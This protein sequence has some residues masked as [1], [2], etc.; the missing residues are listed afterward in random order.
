MEILITIVSFLLLIALI[1]SPILILIGLK[2]RKIE[3]YKFITYLTL[4]VFITSI[5]T[6]AFGWWSDTSREILL[7]YYGYEFDS[8][9]ETERFANV[10]SENLDRVKSLE[11]SMMG[12]GWPL[13]TIITFAL[14]S[15]YL[16]FI[17]VV[18]YLIQKNQKTLP[19]QTYDNHAK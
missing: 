12:I 7:S 11:I 4:G 6:L 17:Y 15:P 19:T 5:I 18:T 8:M 9:N 16:L 3:K 14:Y 2:R 13:K 10:S 1:T